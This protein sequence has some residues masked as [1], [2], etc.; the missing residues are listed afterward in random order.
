MVLKKHYS[1]VQVLD[2]QGLSFCEEVY[3]PV[4]C[5]QTVRWET[6][7]DPVLL[8]CQNSECNRNR[9]SPEW[10]L[11]DLSTSSLEV[12]PPRRIRYGCLYTCCVTRAVH[13]EVVPDLMTAAFLRCLKRF[14]ARRGLPKQF[15]SDNG[16]TFKAAAKTIK[17][18]LQHKEVQD[19]LS[20]AG[21]Q[22]TFNLARTPWWGGVFERMIRMTKRCLKKMSD[23]QVCHRNP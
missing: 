9:L 7:L 1:Q 5:L 8:H 18:M 2:C 4:N 11:Q 14:T 19:Y 13:L 15:V 17:A 20:G 16:K 6:S 12:L 10:T 23:V 3:S 21:V 22:W